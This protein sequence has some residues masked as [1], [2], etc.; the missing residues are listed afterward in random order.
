MFLQDLYSFSIDKYAQY[1]VQY[2]KFKELVTV[3]PLMQDA[4]AI[5]SIN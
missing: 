3:D 4:E 5:A 2:L 1:Y